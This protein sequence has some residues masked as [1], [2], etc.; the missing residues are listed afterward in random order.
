MPWHDA[1]STW[2]ARTPDAL[3]AGDS[4]FIAILRG[5]DF[6]WVFA[7]RAFER[8]FPDH[9]A[10]GETVRSTFPEAEA[11]GFLALLEQV[12]R[13][14]ERFVGAQAPLV[15][16]SVNGGPTRELFL[17]FVYEPLSDDSGAVTGI[18]LTGFDVTERVRAERALQKREERYR[19]L[20]NSID[21][22]FCLLEMLF[23]DEGRPVD[24]RFLE[25]NATFERQTGLVGAVGRRMRELVPNLEQQWFDNYGKVA[26]TGEPL[27]FIDGSTEMGRWFD[28]Y[29]AR[30]GGADSREVALLFTDITARK[31]DEAERERLLVAEREAR[32]AAEAAVQAR[33]TFLSI[34]AHELKTPLT[35]LKGGAQLLRRRQLRGQLDPERLIGGLD[36]LIRSIDRL[37][38]LTDDLLDVARLRTGQ[39]P[40]IA[41]PLDLAALTAEAVSNFRDRDDANDRLTLEVPPALPAVLADSARIEQVIDNLLD[42]AIKYSPAGG[43]VAVTVR[44]E[45][46]GILLSVQDA[47]IGLPAGAAE[48]IFEPFGRAANAAMSTL[49]GMGLGL[50]I[51]RSIIER[52]GGWIRAKSAG[53]GQGTLVRFWLPFAGPT[54]APGEGS[55]DGAASSD[56]TS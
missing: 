52:H 56:A 13:T 8:L 18:I 46:A 35:A 36:T 30:V 38:T 53:E 45:G 50:F 17:D 40:L 20:F 32:E 26:L 9:S 11:Q 22:G 23:D 41:N 43:A 55:P 42:N 7:N 21:E 47:G 5:P 2:A 1:L 10:I 25:T 48:S 27:R 33:D 3:F 19:T 29:A 51:C 16:H 54:D 4:G 24:Y 28:V 44:T 15:V 49:P 37:T 34:A 6:R 31:A 39:L 14:G 12:Y